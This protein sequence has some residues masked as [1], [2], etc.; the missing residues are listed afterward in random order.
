M[1]HLYSARAVSMSDT[2]PVI[3]FRYTPGSAGGLPEFDSSAKITA[4]AARSLFY[5]FDFALQL[6]S[7][8]FE[9]P[10]IVIPPAQQEDNYYL[11]YRQCCSDTAA[12]PF[13]H[14]PEM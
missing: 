8:P 2:R 9:G 13:G 10:A 5:V 1:T 14:H 7:G 12:G 11:G 6:R 3:S 4:A